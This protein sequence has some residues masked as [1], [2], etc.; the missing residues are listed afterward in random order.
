MGMEV[1]KE[2]HVL[3]KHVLTS[4][5]HVK[6]QV[7]AFLNRGFVMVI[8]IVLTTLMKMAVHQSLVPHRSS[9]AAI[10]SSVY[11]SRT[12]VMAYLTVMMEVMN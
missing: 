6:D 10:S 12:S 9:N 7:T 8:M 2:I 3:R 1:M 5:S 11:T 4:N